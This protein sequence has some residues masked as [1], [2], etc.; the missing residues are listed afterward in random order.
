MAMIHGEA[1]Q[2]QIQVLMTSKD[3]TL[4]RNRLTWITRKGGSGGV[5]FDSSKFARRVLSWIRGDLLLKLVL[6][7]SGDWRVI[8][9]MNLINSIRNFD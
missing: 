7:R 9:Y 6:P 2:P 1:P 4:L 8:C 5:L 3:C